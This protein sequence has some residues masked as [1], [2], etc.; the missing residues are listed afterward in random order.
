MSEWRSALKDAPDVGVQVICWFEDED[1]SGCH[2][3]ASRETGE[4]GKFFW[5]SVEGDGLQPP[6]YWMPLPLP[7]ENSGGRNAA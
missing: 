3:I 1:G 2:V 6:K 7:P 4:R 5:M